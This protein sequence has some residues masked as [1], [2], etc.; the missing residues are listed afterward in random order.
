MLLSSKAKRFIYDIHM[1]IYKTYIKMPT[2]TVYLP[3]DLYKQ[4]IDKDNISKE[5]QEALRKHMK[6]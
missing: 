5:I 4:L 6:K 3:V 2:I 1:Y